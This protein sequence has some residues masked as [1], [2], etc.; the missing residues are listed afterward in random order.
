[1]NAIELLRSDHD[2]LR[3]MLPRLYDTA[4]ASEE[5]NRLREDVEKEIKIH[6]MLEEEI[7]Y[8]AWKDA[9]DDQKDRDEYFEAIEEHHV[10]DMLLPE[11][12]TLDATDDSFRAKSKVLRELFEHHAGEEEEDMFPRAQQLFSPA[13]LDELGA[14]MVARRNDLNEKWSTTMGNA[15]RKAQAVAEKFA[16]SSMKDARVE[17]NRER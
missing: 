2:R 15:M 7:F 6:S 16:P 9:T 12:M 3:E 5:R 14:K 13:R 1:M 4:I 17:A 8:P 11:L 10:V